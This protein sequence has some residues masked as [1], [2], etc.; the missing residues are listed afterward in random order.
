M[1]GFLQQTAPFQSSINQQSM[2]GPSKFREG[3][4]KPPQSLL[5]SFQMPSQTLHVR[6]TSHVQNP[7]DFMQ[8]CTYV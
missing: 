5:D 2:K 1:V 8:V 3:R 7:V 4:G 6:L